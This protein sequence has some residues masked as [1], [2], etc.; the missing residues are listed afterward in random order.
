MVGKMKRELTTFQKIAEIGLAIIAVVVEIVMTYITVYLNAWPAI[1]HG[2]WM[3][4]WIP[5]VVW[6]FLTILWVSAIAF[7]LS[8]TRRKQLK[9]DLW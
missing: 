6:I 3:V 7:I 2:Y 4:V 1:Q 8:R 9:R 5:I